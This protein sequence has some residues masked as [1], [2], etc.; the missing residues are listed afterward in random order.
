MKESG[1]MGESYSL[2]TTLTRAGRQVNI[3]VFTDRNYSKWYYS[4]PVLP[5]DV[6]IEYKKEAAAKR[7]ILLELFT[8]G[9]LA[10]GGLLLSGHTSSLFCNPEGKYLRRDNGPDPALTKEYIGGYF[11]ELLK[12]DL[13]PLTESQ[14]DKVH[15]SGF[16]DYP[17]HF[18]NLAYFNPLN[19]AMS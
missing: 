16:G 4:T 5:G 15:T 8:E 10:E 11:V 3:C 1:A 12:N 2:S 7:I 6:G 17:L 9:S 13:L 19:P 14:I 18:T